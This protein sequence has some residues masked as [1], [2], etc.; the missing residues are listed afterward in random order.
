MNVICRKN[1]SDDNNQAIHVLVNGDHLIAFA[2]IASEMG[3]SVGSVQAVLSDT[4]G[5]S[6]VSARWIPL[7]LRHRE[8]F[9]KTPVSG[10]LI[11]LKKKERHF[12]TI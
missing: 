9:R 6:K 2:E 7:P 11:A 12:W 8:M 10:F 5:Y 1:I 4:L 3:I